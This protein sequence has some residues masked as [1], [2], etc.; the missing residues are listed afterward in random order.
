MSQRGVAVNDEQVRALVPL[1]MRGTVEDIAAAVCF[2]ASPEAAYI[3]GH[4]L[5]V[6][7]GWRAK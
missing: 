1:G 2:L 7:G 5:V 6:D 4:S 3:N